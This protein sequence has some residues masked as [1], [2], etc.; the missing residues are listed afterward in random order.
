[1]MGS[2]AQGYRIHGVSIGKIRF[3]RFY[4]GHSKAVLAEG[5]GSRL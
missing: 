4:G 5:A 2:A 1:M 3:D